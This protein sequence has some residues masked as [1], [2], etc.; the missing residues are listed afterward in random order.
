MVIDYRCA[1]CNGPVTNCI[2]YYINDNGDLFRIPTKVCINEQCLVRQGA[3]V[4]RAVERAY[5]TLSD[6]ALSQPRN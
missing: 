6:Y 4:M 3:T 1:H 5:P 2:T